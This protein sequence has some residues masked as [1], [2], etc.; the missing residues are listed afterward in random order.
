MKYQSQMSRVDSIIS[1]MK[2]GEIQRYDYTFANAPDN[3]HNR[4]K[5]EMEGEDGSIV[6][7]GGYTVQVKIASSA[8]TQTSTNAKATKTLLDNFGTDLIVTGGDACVPPNPLGAYGATLACIFADM[9]VNL[10]VAHGHLH[11]IVN[12]WE[13]LMERGESMVK[14]DWITRVNE[15]K[16][17]FTLHYD[18]RGRSENYFQL[19]QTLICN[20]YSLPPLVAKQ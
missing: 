12:E 18:A 6:L 20:L 7:E 15:L 9:F 11:A 8:T 10:A 1:K 14:S 16:T 4:S 17:L 19:V 3:E 5:Q 13:S 2:N